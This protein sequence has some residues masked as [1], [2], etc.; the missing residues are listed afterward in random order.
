MQE[1]FSF[2]LATAESN[3]QLSPLR[4]ETS[5]L[6]L[7]LVHIVADVRQL[8]ERRPRLLVTLPQLCREQTTECFLLIALIILYFY[9]SMNFDC[10]VYCA[11]LIEVRFNNGNCNQKL[12][13]KIGKIFYKN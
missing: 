3:H 1:V 6:V 12:R 5:Q 7:T 2:L 11:E 8:A 10:K 4:G 9:I 13:K